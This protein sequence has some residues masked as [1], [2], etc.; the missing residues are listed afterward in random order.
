MALVQKYL[1]GS[2]RMRGWA[3]AGSSNNF[4][5]NLIAYYKLDEASGDALDATANAKTLTQYNTIGTAAGIINGGRT[6]P[7]TAGYYHRRDADT[8]FGQFGSNYFT[9][10]L[11]VKP[12]SLSQGT[13][14]GIISKFA[15]SNIEWGI[16]FNDGNK[17]A[18]LDVSSN[19]TSETTVDA[20]TAFPDTST[21]LFV[22]AGWD[23][24]NIWI[25]VNGGAF[26][27]T[28]WSSNLFTGTADFYL[29]ARTGTPF[30]GEIDEVGIWSGR[31]LSLSEVQQLY[32]S[33]AALPYSSFA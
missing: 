15:T 5:T 16:L 29:G 2:F 30:N 24:V 28:P 9:V 25:S 3:N 18:Y 10:T 4:L 7:G 13:Y 6:Y 22:A 19:G 8:T 14:P 1:A 11:W 32:N 23:G 12:G 17:K 26:A 20:A 21:W 33:G 31:S 27:T